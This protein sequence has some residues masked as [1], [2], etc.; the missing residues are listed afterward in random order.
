LKVV[1]R[2][3]CVTKGQGQAFTARFGYSNPNSVVKVLPLSN[4][5][6]VTPAPRDQGQPRVFRSGDHSNVFTATSP[7]G[8]L[9]WHLDG[10]T[11]EAARNLA[12]QCGTMP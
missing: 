2:V 12:V 7:G 8:N 1:P 6:E 5:N 11:A 9:Q 3:E 10:A 4:L